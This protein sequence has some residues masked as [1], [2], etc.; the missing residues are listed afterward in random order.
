MISTDLFLAYSTQTFKAR[1]G[2]AVVS[3]S[4]S[5]Y[6]P[7]KRTEVSHRVDISVVMTFCII[8]QHVD[9]MKMNV[10]LLPPSR[11]EEYAHKDEEKDLAEER[12][13]SLSPKAC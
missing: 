4:I 2:I 10:A 5:R 9:G 1:W 6:T 7:G 3:L 13:G 8:H 11:E 12:I